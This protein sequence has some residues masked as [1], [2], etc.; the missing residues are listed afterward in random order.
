M[1]NEF[2]NKKLPPNII[3]PSILLI[4]VIKGTGDAVL[5]KISGWTCKNGSLIASFSTDGTNGM[6]SKSL[7][8]YK[9]I[10]INIRWKIGTTFGMFDFLTF[11]NKI[12]AINTVIVYSHSKLIGINKWYPHTVSVL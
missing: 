5:V 8:P 2:K 10:K 11:K 1:I 12:F 3:M 9:K 4:P 7:W 6:L